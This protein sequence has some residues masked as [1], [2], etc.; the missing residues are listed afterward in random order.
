M[1]YY[2]SLIHYVAT[3]RI[4]FKNIFDHYKHDEDFFL[5][6]CFRNERCVSPQLNA[7]SSLCMCAQWS[8][9]FNYSLSLGGIIVF[10]LWV[11]FIRSSTLKKTG[12]LV[13]HSLIEEPYGSHRIEQQC[14]RSHCRKANRL[15]SGRLLIDYL[16]GTSNWAEAQGM[17]SGAVP[18]T[19]KR[20]RCR[21][22]LGHST[23]FQMLL[24]RS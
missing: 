15:I 9:V 23:T 14:R 5:S 4:D 18:G 11:S 1:S 24:M 13:T 10:L 2:I 20:R 7:F 12:F 21:I 19:G 17:G 3:E 22:S 8:L 6:P 16:L